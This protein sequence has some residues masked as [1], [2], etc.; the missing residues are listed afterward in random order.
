MKLTLARALVGVN[1]GVEAE[2][3]N[4][5]D[6]SRIQS[7]SLL[8]VNKTRHTHVYCDQNSQRIPKLLSPINRKIYSEQTHKDSPAPHPS[9]ST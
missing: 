6:D 5:V 4:P 7:N 8:P 2:A 9:S 3:V 1:T